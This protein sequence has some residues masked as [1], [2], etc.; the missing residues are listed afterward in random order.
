M[1]AG[2]RRIARRGPLRR[3]HALV[4]LRWL[5]LACA[6]AA[7]AL[8]P[9]R[10]LWHYGYAQWND[11]DGLPQNTV[12]AIAQTKDGY[13]W[14]GTEAG[15]VRFNGRS[16]RTFDTSGEPALRSNS[17]TALAASPDGGLWIGTR[18]GLLRLDNGIFRRWGAEEGLRNET[19]RA[20]A[21]GAD[22]VIWVGTN[23]GIGR[24]DGAKFEWFTRER[25]LPNIAIRSL[26][27]SGGVLWAG[28][29]G[30]LARISSG[31]AEPVAGI[32]ADTVRA[33]LT[34][35]AGRV[36]IGTETSGLYSW[37]QGSP[38]KF[39]LS[40][41][42]RSESIRSLLEDR[43]GNL[44]IGT[45]GGGL[46]RFSGGTVESMTQAQGLA[47]D[48]IRSLF[49]DREGS[50]W[51]GTEAGGLA[52]FKEGRAVTW[53][54]IDGLRSEFVRAVRGNQKGQL[55]IGTEGGGLHVLADGKLTPFPEPALA[56]SFVTA[57]LP[58]RDGS[59]WIGT[60]GQGAFHL[61]PGGKEM[62]STAFGLSENS[63]WALA[64]DVSGSVWLGSSNGLVK[65][66]TAGQRVF[67]TTEGLRG[68]SI[69][70][71]HAAADGT[72]W[73]ANRNSGL[74]RM[75]GEGFE[76]IEL[77]E[78]ARGAAITSFL[79]EPGGGIWMSSSRGVL[80][81]D[82]SRM[83]HAGAQ[84]GLFSENLYQVLER[85]GQLWFSSMRGIFHVDKAE[86]RKLFSGG[87]EKVSAAMVTTSGG[88]RS[89]ECS[90]DAQP[91]GWRQEDGSLWFATIRGLA[92]IPAGPGPAVRQRPN[93]VI[94]RVEINGSEVRAGGGIFRSPAGH[95]LL[96]VHFAALT[97]LSPMLTR[98]RYRLRGHDAGWTDSEGATE[99]IYHNLPPGGY[100]FEVQAAHP[101]G[102]WGPPSSAL[103]LSVAP[104]FHES[105]WFYFALAGAVAMFAY[106]IHR[107]RT[108]V[109]Q[110]EFAAVLGE[111]SR[112]A[113][114]IHDTLLQGFAGAALQLGAISKR[115]SR[116]PE[117]ARRDLDGVL[118]QIDECLAEA[119]QEIGELR[120]ERAAGVPL[121]ERLARA[122]A[123]VCAGSGV[124]A[125][126]TTLGSARR[127]APE[128]EKNL[129]RIARESVA[130]A[131]RHGQPRHIAIELGYG[132]E[133]V[134][135]LVRDDG[136]GM[137]G[138]DPSRAHF[139]ITGMRE[140]TE[141]LG[142][143]FALRSAARQG[144][145]IEVIL[146]VR[147][148]A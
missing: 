61:T 37:E 36:W 76:E 138:A 140:R 115:V 19:V 123:S 94:E 24:F 64:Q 136:R 111:R 58:S 98:Y 148:D 35:R 9:S 13:L 88:L 85:E 81:W 70:A 147:S 108:Q 53:S 102:D 20:L 12:Q 133:H 92:Q 62:F 96:A 17:V 15:L 27:F 113:R 66:S 86:V 104:S 43:D 73:V 89:S 30:G 41:S 47:S 23:A 87:V 31:R 7:H 95:R 71:L 79:E 119:R 68:N 59:L 22:G 141:L 132:G 100:E 134:R 144:T 54:A 8:E 109:L 1:T 4:V 103:R 145:E 18:G 135:F 131:I 107:Q 3:Y 93:A 26:A 78:S 11:R 56:K 124:T 32:P 38:R 105:G 80:R 25:G 127:L 29:G 34:D 28:T 116:D 60:E 90:G 52:Q 130:N 45:V 122:A 2:P 120:G 118:D 106:W 5:L 125:E 84:Q 112:I 6:L 117:R 139:G 42:L 72:L 10:R 101:H 77:P 143:T 99:A 46:H 129:L 55:W 57:I 40:S 97:Y 128:I 16:F 82:G 65:V 21:L 48:H 67:R 74:Q 121:P 126:V 91:A 51:A 110:R 44:W 69:R 142:G 39:A 63:V 75:R 33:L 83:F 137:D 114:E 146:P 50:V 14:L 49:E